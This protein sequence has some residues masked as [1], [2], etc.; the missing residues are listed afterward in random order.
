VKRVIA[1]TV[2]MIYRYLNVA[3]DLLLANSVAEFC[4][5]YLEWTVDLIASIYAAFCGRQILVL[6]SLVYRGILKGELIDI[7]WDQV[8]KKQRLCC[9]SIYT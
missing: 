5:M 7:L 6:R 3:V 1:E 4:N 8:A 2:D 9:L